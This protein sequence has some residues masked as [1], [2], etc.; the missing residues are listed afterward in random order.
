VAAHISLN[1]VDYLEVLDL[2]AP[3]G[4]PRQQTLLVRCLKPAPALTVDNVRIEGGERFDDIGVLWVVVADAVPPAMIS[5]GEITAAEAAYFAALPDPDQVLVVRTDSSGDYSPYRLRLVTADNDPTPP[6]G[7]DLRLAAIEF[8]FKVECENDFDCKPRRICPTPAAVEPK[9]DYL[10][11]DFASF[12]RLMLDRLSLLAP[13][14]TERSPADLGVALVELLAYVG[15]HLSYQQ[16]AVATEAYLGTARRRISIRRHARLVDYFLSDGSNARAWVQLE[17]PVDV[18]PAVPGQP[19]VPKGTKLFTAIPG[20]TAATVADDPRVWGDAKS[21]F[22]TMEPIPELFGA[23][24]RIPFYTWSDHE[25][26]LPSGAT[27]ATLLGSLPDLEPGMVL[28]FEEVLGPKTG[29]P[30]DADPAHRHPVRLTEVTAATDPLDGTQLTEIC[31]EPDDVLPFPLCLSSRTDRAHHSAFVDDVSVA[32]G[33][34]VLADHGL[35]IEDEDLGTVPEPVAFYA[36][37]HAADRCDP[38]D[39]RPVAPRFRPRLGEAP[40][41]QAAPYGA[42]GAARKAMKWNHRH[43]LPEAKLTGLAL[44]V[45]SPWDPRRDLLASDSDH[46]HFV[47][48]VE[49]DG[50]TTL[51]FG[52]GVHGKRSKAGMLFTATYRVGNGRAGNIGIDSLRHAAVPIP[53]IERV[54]NLTPGQG[55]T[56]PES[57]EN[58]RQKAPVAF[59]TQER[60]VTEADYSDVTERDPEVQ[61]A[62][63]SFR[64]TGSW[65]TA[66]LTVD[67][68]GGLEVD[69]AFEDATRAHVERYRMAGYDLEVDGPR[70]VS[71]EIELRV[72]VHP[73]HFRSDVRAALEEKLSDEILPGGRLGVFHP[74]NFVFGQPVFLSRIYAAA[75]EVPGVASVHVTNFR[76]QDE[77]ETDARDSG[78]LEI[79]RLEIARLENDRS[80]PGHGVLHLEL[81]GGK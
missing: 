2:D 25:C 46:R 43:V 79:G 7:F 17:V 44:G 70:P 66:F 12:R 78:I 14:W 61:K 9:I 48:E 23:H 51:R 4:S 35:T 13:E 47:V 75:Q 65:H 20:V 49:N 81:E 1:G 6:P 21:V 55:G 16:D 59:R 42:T 45:S 76:R 33:N 58:V 39:P 36:P 57:M 69:A 10:T 62:A 64:W 63:A 34:V 30:G 72:C 52:E 5:S 37:G 19:V 77:P 40:V 22:E 32:R 50:A 18:P 3:A 31:W 80:Y 68:F 38:D 8:S 26:C 41:T 74:D 60:A 73:D 71:L 54:R 27:A 11:K 53:L 15:D 29:H 67:R 28:V 56:E 24:S